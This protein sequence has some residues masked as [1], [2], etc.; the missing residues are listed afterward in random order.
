MINISNDSLYGLSLTTLWSQHKTVTDL[1]LASRC[2]VWVVSYCLQNVSSLRTYPFYWRNVS[3]ETV[4]QLLSRSL[5]GFL[6][7]VCRFTTYLVECVKTHR[8][9]CTKRSEM[10]L[11]KSNLSRFL[12]R[13]SRKRL[14]QGM[15]SPP[16]VHWQFS[17][18]SGSICIIIEDRFCS[19]RH[20]SHAGTWKRRIISRG[21]NFRW[22][23][24]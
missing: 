8:S 12:F 14:N 21:A 24:L 23:V 17:E 22:E 5:A 19:S 9:R 10:S 3:E 16:L 11:K 2:G 18:T 1:K 6:Q 4:A 15:P 13:R 20:K 7:T